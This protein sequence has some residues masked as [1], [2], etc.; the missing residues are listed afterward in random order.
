MSGASEEGQVYAWHIP[1]Q[2]LT[3]SCL[4]SV[5]W[6]AWQEPEVEAFYFWLAACSS[7]RA[8]TAQEIMELAARPGELELLKA[9]DSRTSAQVQGGIR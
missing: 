7:E 1:Q 2:C 3:I 5:H 6:A 4:W 8:H 9:Q